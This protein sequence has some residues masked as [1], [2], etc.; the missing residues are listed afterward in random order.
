MVKIKKAIQEVASGIT[1]LE[2][3]SNEIDEILNIINNIAEQTNLLALNAA[4]EA[5]RA[6]EAGR[7]FSV[8]ADEIRELA[9]ESVN[10]AGEIRKLVE[11]V[12][13]ETN[14]ASKRMDEGINEI[15][16]GE[17]VVSSAEKS[18]VEIENKIKNVSAGISSS[19]GIVA[20]VDRYSENIVEEVGEIASISEET[21]ANTEEVA[22]ASQEQNASIEEI[23]SLADSLSEMSAN[24]NQ[25][26]KRFELN[27]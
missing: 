21:S 10:S 27:N 1:N 15:Q 14:T 25:L 18:F 19:I 23:T 8:V 22:A 3:I 6:G 24:L 11:D 12:K 5:A 17:E 13:A 20:D 2:S 4:I 9:E 7:G 16:N 26:V